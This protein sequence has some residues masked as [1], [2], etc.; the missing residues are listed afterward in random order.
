MK[1]FKLM[2]FLSLII[3]FTAGCSVLPTS[4][5]NLGFS[6]QPLGGVPIEKP[7]DEEVPFSIGIS[8]E[9]NTVTHKIIS[10]SGEGDEDYG[11]VPVNEYTMELSSITKEGNIITYTYLDEDNNSVTEELEIM[12]KSVM[13]SKSSN[14]YYEYFGPREW[15]LTEEDN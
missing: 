9:D 12:S 6:M 13:K 8:D 2:L 10:Q 4:E 5:E 1:R 11:G 15:G 14:N 7:D 3:L